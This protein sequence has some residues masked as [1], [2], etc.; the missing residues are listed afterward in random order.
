MLEVDVSDIPDLVPILA[1]NAMI[2]GRDIRLYNATRL[3]LKE[4]NRIKSVEELIKSLGGNIITTDSELMINGTS[5]LVGGEADSFNDHR[6]VMSAAIASCYCKKEVIIRN[7]EAVE[8]S[9][10][11]FFKDFESLGGKFNVL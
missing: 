8:K 10:S 2:S 7:A 1:V 9:Y 6:I 11:E 5:G 3:K 4:S